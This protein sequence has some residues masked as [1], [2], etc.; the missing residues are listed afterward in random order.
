MSEFYQG[1][2]MVVAVGAVGLI[3]Y[4]IIMTNR[5]H[6]QEC[7]NLTE[8]LKKNYSAASQEQYDASLSMIIHNPNCYTTVKETYCTAMSSAK[9]SNNEFCG[10]SSGSSNQQ[11]SNN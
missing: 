3:G 2:I 5:N 7:A 4:N 1:F 8:S 6:A 9:K 11:S 10:N